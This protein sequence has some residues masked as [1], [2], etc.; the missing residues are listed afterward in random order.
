SGQTTGT[1]TTRPPVT[2]TTSTSQGATDSMTDQPDGLRCET[3]TDFEDAESNGRWAVV[4][5]DVMGGR[6]LGGL[7]FVDGALLFEGDINTNGGGFASLRLA[8]EPEALVGAD[9]IRFRARPDGRDYMVTFDDNLSSRDRRVSHRA[10]IG[11]DGAGEWQ[12]VSVAFADLFPAIFGQPVDDLPFRPD[13]ATRLGLM[14]SDGR[15][16]PFRLDVDRIEL[17]QDPEPAS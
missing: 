7:A 13:L 1:T 8:L 17:C 9:H 5:D 15:D 10:P 16:G 3:L 11:F 2:T 6:S 12:T 4:N 14:I